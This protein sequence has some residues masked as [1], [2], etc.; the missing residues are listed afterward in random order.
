MDTNDIFEAQEVMEMG[1]LFDD[2]PFP[3]GINES[4]NMVS[5]DSYNA[6]P[7]PP[8]FA[9]IQDMDDFSGFDESLLFREI[10]ETTNMVSQD[11]YNPYEST[12][13]LPR[14]KSLNK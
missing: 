10:A 5:Q 12:R 2:V 11:F 3:R 8:D 7:L 13:I 6:S 1:D 4:D 9:E 14:Q